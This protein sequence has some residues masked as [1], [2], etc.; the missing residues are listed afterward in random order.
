MHPL[1]KPVVH[2]LYCIQ[3]RHVWFK[4]CTASI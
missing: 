4:N 1:E 2:K 3:L